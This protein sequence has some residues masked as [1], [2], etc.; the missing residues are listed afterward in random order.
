M[1]RQMIKVC[2]IDVGITNLGISL[3]K[4]I[5]EP[6]FQLVEVVQC[7]T[8]NLP[9]VTSR[10]CKRGECCQY[11]DRSYSHHVRHFVEEHRS[12]YFEP[13]TLILIE[14]QPMTYLTAV[15]QLLNFIFPKKVL[16][17]SPISLHHWMGTV[18]ASRE[19]KKK[20]SLRRALP[21]V[22]DMPGFKLLKQHKHDLADAVVYT[23]FYLHN[24]KKSY[25]AKMDRNHFRKFQYEVKRSKYFS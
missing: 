22:K 11:Q 23:L 3:S 14:Q 10:V 4:V 24:R 8:I 1:G 21:Y 13:A 9:R 6:K 17:Q 25:E 7:N 20:E 12:I 15:E 5:L 2:S 18:G 16:L 19:E